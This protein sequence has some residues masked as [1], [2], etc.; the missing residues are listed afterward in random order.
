MR[1]STG[2]LM[3]CLLPVLGCEPSA[4]DPGAV[5]L[6]LP[7]V[8]ESWLP[9]LPVAV[10]GCHALTTTLECLRLPKDVGKPVHLWLPGDWDTQKISVEIHGK[11]RVH[12]ETIKGDLDG[13]WAA[14]Q[15]PASAKVVLRYPGYQSFVLQIGPASPGYVAAREEIRAKLKNQEPLESSEIV[16][17]KTQLNDLEAYLLDCWA[18][19]AYLPPPD[20]RM[21]ALR[22]VRGRAEEIG[23]VVCANGLATRLIHEATLEQNL[24]EATSRLEDLL[25]HQS[26]DLAARA[27][28]EYYAAIIAQKKGL[29]GDARHGFY[30]AIHLAARVNSDT[31]ASALDQQAML[32][33]LI[34]RLDEAARLYDEVPADA[35][36]DI[37]LTIRSNKAWLDILRRAQDPSVADPSHEL[38]QLVRE[39]L[40]KDNLR[41]AAIARL[42]VAVA[43]IQNGDYRLAAQKL[44]RVERAR[45][46]LRQQ[47]Y[48]ELTDFRIA[49]AAGNPTMA[50]DR[51]DRADALA[52]ATHDREFL[53]ELLEARVELEL[54]EGDKQSALAVFERADQLADK[55]VLQMPASAGRSSYWATLTR[56]RAQHVELALAVGNPERALCTVLGARIRHLRAQALGGTLS[57]QNPE[58]QRQYAQLLNQYRALNHEL[59]EQRS[60]D[61]KLSKQELLARKHERERDTR[62]LDELLEQLMTMREVDTPIW[63]CADVR[64]SEHSRALLTAY[65]GVDKKTWTF[66]LDRDS[67]VSWVRMEGQLDPNAMVKQALDQFSE[68]GKLDGVT[69]LTVVPLAELLV[70]DFAALAAPRGIRIRHGLGLGTHGFGAST[71]GLA[72]VVGDGSPDLA[73]IEPELASV[74]Q[75]L[76]DRGWTLTKRWNPATTEQPYLLHYGGH[77]ERAGLA[78]WD[79]HLTLPDGSHLTTEQ[80]ML[81][82]HAP[83]VVVLSACEGGAVDPAMLDGGMNVAVALLL[84]GA[85]LVVAADEAIDDELARDFARAFHGALPDQQNVDVD[86]A[87]VALD[88]IQRRDPRFRAWR[89]WVP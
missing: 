37:L 24:D 50:R 8:Q 51:L 62:T 59:D 86:A 3:S 5:G 44:A 23:E 79:S 16:R 35:N 18:A 66:L 55:L 63:R 38:D 41:G 25:E 2:W 65:P 83:G 68:L 58:R 87:I 77:G 54:Y 61:W 85:E 78:G 74:R 81:E 80:L 32:L 49:L 70:V 46:D 33:A 9:E 12:D 53:L 14:L 69:D 21:R 10:G 57:G 40:E 6:E 13:V 56:S 88:L 30:R 45:I 28:A 52:D 20:A 15:P 71:I 34:G 42:N 7:A 26:H 47:L 43:A 84:G 67:S 4:D 76:G 48:Y 17:L 60:S 19:R 27:S 36:A 89:A 82:G 22:D 29:L 1:R 11:P 75:I 73:A 64:P 39:F 31:Y 72:A